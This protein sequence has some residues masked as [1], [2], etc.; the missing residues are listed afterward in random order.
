M[1]GIEIVIGVISFIVATIFVAARRWY[2]RNK[3]K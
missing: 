3:G 1:E 2:Q